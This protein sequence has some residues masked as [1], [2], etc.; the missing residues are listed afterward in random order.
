[1]YI[2]CKLFYSANGRLLKLKDISL[3]LVIC[4]LHVHS[5]TSV[6]IMNDKYAQEHNVLVFN[7][8]GTDVLF[9]ST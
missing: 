6:T 9:F 8:M 3:Q 4:N 5:D 1:M 7:I 2:F